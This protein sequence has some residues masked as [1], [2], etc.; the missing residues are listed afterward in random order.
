MATKFRGQYEAYKREYALQQAKLRRK[1]YEMY[2]PRY[3]EL[4][5]STMYVAKRNEFKEL[6]KEGKRKQIGNITQSLVREQAYEFS[7]SQAKA[8]KEAAK[9]TNQDLTYTQIRKGQFDWSK[10]SADRSTLI[11]AGVSKADVA[12]IIAQTYFGSE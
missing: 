11:G 9:V 5:F 12:I 10:I 6:I 1:G 3:S 2:S 8:M 4:E 7:S